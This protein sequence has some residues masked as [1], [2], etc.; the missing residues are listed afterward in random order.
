M[1]LIFRCGESEETSSFS[2][3]KHQIKAANVKGETIASRVTSE[4]FW[5][6][7]LSE[8]DFAGD[9]NRK[10]KKTKHQEAV[11]KMQSRGCCRSADKHPPLPA[12]VRATRLALSSS[13]KLH[14]SWWPPI[15]IPAV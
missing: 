1:L 2:V 14:R 12:P 10:Q 8:P 5:S 9:M 6:A 3:A 11:T 4:G 15:I 7:I 13:C